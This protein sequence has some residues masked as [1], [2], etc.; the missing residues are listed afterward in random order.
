MSSSVTSLTLPGYEDVPWLLSR[1]CAGEWSYEPSWMDYVR[2]PSFIN[3]FEKISRVFVIPSFDDRSVQ[4]ALEIVR[5][6]AR[7]VLE[8]REVKHFEVF[9]IRN[10]GFKSVPHRKCEE[11]GCDM[12]SWLGV[13]FVR[14]N[15]ES[16]H[17]VGW[18][19]VARVA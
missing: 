1:A 8:N 18:V 19:A 4:I 14:S 17:L 10:D 5:R 6:E 16:A 15:T 9:P 11:R 12:C 7:K 3:R 13:V 2:H